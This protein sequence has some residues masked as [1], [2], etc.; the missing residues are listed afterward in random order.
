MRSKQATPYAIASQGLGLMHREGGYG[1][2][3]IRLGT[4]RHV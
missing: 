3:I 1:G 4:Q 2:S